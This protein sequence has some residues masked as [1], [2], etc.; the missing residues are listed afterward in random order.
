MDKDKMEE[1]SVYY[2]WHTICITPR[3]LSQRGNKN[4]KALKEP[5][6]MPVARL[7]IRETETAL[8]C[9]SWCKIQK[10]KGD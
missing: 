3:K 6:T 2:T 9:M 7:L 8:S 1:I 5:H 4:H 10:Q